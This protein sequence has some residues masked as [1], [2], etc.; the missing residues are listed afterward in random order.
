MEASLSGGF[1]FYLNK[2]KPPYCYSKAVEYIFGITS[3]LI[4]AV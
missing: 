3:E 1:L 2:N 4:R